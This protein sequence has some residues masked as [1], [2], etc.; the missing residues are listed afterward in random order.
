VGPVPDP[1]LL[2]KPGSVGNRIRDFWICR[3]EL[4]PLDHRGGRAVYRGRFKHVEGALGTH[5]TVGWVSPTLF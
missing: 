5:F 1:L 3:Q 2:R 4:W